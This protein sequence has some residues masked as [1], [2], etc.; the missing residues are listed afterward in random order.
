MA[1]HS[2]EAERDLKRKAAEELLRILSGKNPFYQMNK[3][4]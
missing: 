2:A 1:W 3:A 4:S